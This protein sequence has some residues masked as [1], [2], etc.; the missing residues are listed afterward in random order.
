[1]E[2]DIACLGPDHPAIIHAQQPFAQIL[3]GASLLPDQ[4]AV[5]PG[6]WDPPKD[7]EYST[8]MFTAAFFRGVEEASKFLPTDTADN[9]PRSKETSGRRDSHSVGGDELEADAGRT[10]SPQSNR[11]KPAPARCLKK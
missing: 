11:R 1:M 7:Q 6:V 9:L 5:F 3:S 4:G 10:T 8:D 2:E